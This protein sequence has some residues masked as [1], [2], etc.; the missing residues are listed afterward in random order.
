VEVRAQVLEA[1]DRVVAGV[2]A[3][4]GVLQAVL[5]A[6]VVAD[7]VQAQAVDLSNHQPLAMR[8][9]AEVGEVPISTIMVLMAADH[10]RVASPAP[11]VAPYSLYQMARAAVHTLPREQ[12]SRRQSATHG[13]RVVIVVLVKRIN[14][15]EMTIQLTSKKLGLTIIFLLVVA[16]VIMAALYFSVWRTA[17]KEYR[18][19]S[20][21]L[22][23]LRTT[24]GD[25]NKVLAEV[26]HSTDIDDAS[27]MSLSKTADQYNV[28]L[29]DLSDNAAVTRDQ[30][31]KSTYTQYKGSLADYGQTVGNLAA[32]LE[33]YRVLLILCSGLVDNLGGIS[34][35]AAFT[36]AA[37]GC[38]SA[39]KDARSAPDT[40]FSSAYLDGYT[41]AAASLLTAYQQQVTAQGNA[42]ALKATENNITAIKK[43][44]T[45]LS[46]NKFDLAPTSPT[47]ALKNLEN[48]V[49]AQQ[50]AIWR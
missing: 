37:N 41:T 15:T 11:I 22:A 3:H 27:V 6:A 17:D 5:V 29:K 24:S 9:I 21:Q 38:D 44:I 12:S 4:R 18:A 2:A 34:T 50:A 33:K 30:S 26:Q 8:R 46:N 25:I 14:T 16:T 32:S 43:D 35:A 39:I 36:A 13:I 45:A 1:A 23:T 49:N 19:A 28:A 42:T 40:S 7:R 20:E 31:I 47:A 10:A 48:V